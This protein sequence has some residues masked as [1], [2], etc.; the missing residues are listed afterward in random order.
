MQVIRDIADWSTHL[1]LKTEEDEAMRRCMLAHRVLH[2]WCAKEAAF[3]QRS[4]EF[5]TMRQLRME[6]L[7]ER[8]DGLLF[9]AAETVQLDDVI[10]AIT[11]PTS[12]AAP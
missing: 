8:A 10:V 6:L 3:K 2:F 4:D 12:S 11:R 5:T 9:D 1:F 7:E